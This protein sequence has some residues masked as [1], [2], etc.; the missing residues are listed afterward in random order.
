MK[1]N[2]PTEKQ[3]RED[4]Q[5]FFNTYTT[6]PTSFPSNQV[7]AV[8]GF[9]ESRKFDRNAAQAVA[10]VLLTQAKLDGINVFQLIDSLKQQD[11]FK[12]NSIVGEVLNYN[13][14]KTSTLGFSTTDKIDSLE[15]RNIMV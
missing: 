2:I 15:T 1:L 3:V 14:I 9:F 11:E 12:L 7:D 5:K 6:E 4:T 10:G 8:V 13:R